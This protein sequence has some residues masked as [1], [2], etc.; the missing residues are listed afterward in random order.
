MKKALIFVVWALFFVSGCGRKIVYVPVS[1]GTMPQEIRTA[2]GAET[3]AQETR[4]AEKRARVN[5]RWAEKQIQYKLRLGL[6]C[7][8]GGYEAVEIHNR[9]GDQANYLGSA[10][11]AKTIFAHPVYVLL[12]TNA[13]PEPVDLLDTQ[14]TVVKNMCPGGSIMLAKSIPPFSPGYVRIFWVANG[15]NAQGQIGQ[16]TSPAAT[17]YNNSWRMRQ[18]ANWVIQL[19]NRTG[20]FFKKK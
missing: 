18:D 10:Y 4:D 11:A 20:G 6:S 14:G 5:Q 2:G 7:P 16:D 13:E 12:A 3:T 8:V 1:A 19:R 15:I 17:V 9:L